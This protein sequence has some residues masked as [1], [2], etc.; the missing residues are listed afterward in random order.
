MYK[1]ETK[2]LLY[3]FL[4]KSMAVQRKRKYLNLALDKRNKKS[5]RR[6]SVWKTIHSELGLLVAQPPL[7]P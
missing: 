4:E 6:M 2:L 5:F 1:L 3:R 7:I